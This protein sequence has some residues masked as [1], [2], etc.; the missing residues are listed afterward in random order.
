MNARYSCFFN[1]SLIDS[2]LIC[3]PWVTPLTET[4]FPTS[5]KTRALIT[6]SSFI[7]KR[8]SVSWFS[9]FLKQFSTQGKYWWA[10]CCRFGYCW[11][12]S[13][14]AFRKFQ[15]LSQNIISI[16]TFSP[17]VYIIL[18]KNLIE[19]LQK[20]INFYVLLIKLMSVSLL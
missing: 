2:Y 11:V 19:I 9:S 20:W 13:S 6:V 4:V 8:C 5:T 16:A 10:E 12:Y 17:C 18:A 1:I 7:I 3:R 15:S 14:A